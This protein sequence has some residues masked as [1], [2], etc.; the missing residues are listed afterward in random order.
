[1]RF[2]GTLARAALGVAERGATARRAII[3]AVAYGRLLPREGGEA[4]AAAGAENRLAGFGTS[5]FGSATS[6]DARCAGCHP[7]T[8]SV[9]PV[10]PRRCALKGEVQPGQ[11][12]PPSL[13]AHCAHG[14]VPGRPDPHRDG[15]AIEPGVVAPTIWPV[16]HSWPWHAENEKSFRFHQPLSA[17]PL[18]SDVGPIVPTPALGLPNR[19]GRSDIPR[20]TTCGHAV[21]PARTSHMCS[22][23]SPL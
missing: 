15:Q 9:I 17:P 16:G 12:V 4:V 7:N 22:V 8:S 6:K 14:R 21:P 3:A 5:H 13:C 19:P 23:C 2:A 11:E 10:S 20:M 18:F 1:M